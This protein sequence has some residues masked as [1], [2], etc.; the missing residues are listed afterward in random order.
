MEERKSKSFVELIVWQKAHKFVVAVYKITKNYPNSELF[1]LVSQFRRAAVSIAANIAEGYRKTG[2]A[3]KLRFMNIAQGSLEE[4]RYYVILSADLN[5]IDEQI[6]IELTDLIV[7]V[8]KL[9]NAYSKGILATDNNSFNSF[10][11]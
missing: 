1:G 11:S 3:D 6:K 5:Y 4:C 10:N 7:E 2:K 8:S 9:L